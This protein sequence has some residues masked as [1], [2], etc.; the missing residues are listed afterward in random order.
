MAILTA[1]CRQGCSC[2]VRAGARATA[3]HLPVLPTEGRLLRLGL[4]TPE[5]AGLEKGSCKDMGGSREA[6]LHP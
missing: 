2:L 5:N 6:S 4:H 3:N 1:E